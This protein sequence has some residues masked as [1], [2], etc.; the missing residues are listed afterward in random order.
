MKEYLFQKATKTF[1]N[2]TRKEKNEI[3]HR[4]K[5]FEKFAKYLK[6]KK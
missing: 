1:S 3:S 5:A 2:F 4:R 6:S